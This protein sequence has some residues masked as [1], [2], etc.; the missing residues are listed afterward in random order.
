[1]IAASWTLADNRAIERENALASL[2]NIRTELLR[3]GPIP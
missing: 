3:R 1:M 2:R